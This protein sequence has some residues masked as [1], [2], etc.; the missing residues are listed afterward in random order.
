MF[1]KKISETDE[2]TGQLLDES[3]Y[4][5]EVLLATS[6][7]M[8]R[9]I[10]LNYYRNENAYVITVISIVEFDKQGRCKKT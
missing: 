10:S 8:R 6:G 7:H 5:V 3:R 2:M 4:V 9:L 1:D